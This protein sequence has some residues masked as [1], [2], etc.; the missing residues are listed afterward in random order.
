[1]DYAFSDFSAPEPRSRRRVLRELAGLGA[2]AVALG[3]GTGILPEGTPQAMA[4]D[5]V[6]RRPPV[7]ARRFVSP[8]VEAEIARV[9]AMIGDPELAW[10]FANCYPNTLDTTVEIAMRGGKP[11]TFVITGDIPAMWL[12]DSS[13][14]VW[15]YLH[16]ARDDAALQRLYRGLIARHAQCI[17]IDPYANAF[18]RDPGATRTP[19]WWALSDQTQM[20]P[21]VAERK[22]EVDSLCH[23]VRLAYGYWRATGDSAPFDAQWHQAARLIVF[24]LRTEQRRDG[25]SPYRFQRSTP[26]PTDSLPMG[27]MGSPTRKVGLIHSMFRPSDDACVFPFL[28]PSN[29]FAVQALRWLAEIAATVL[30]DGALAHDAVALA[31]EVAAAVQAWGRI[32]DGANAIWAYEV[33]GFGNTLFMDDANAPSLASLAYLGCVARDDPMFRRTEARCWSTANPYYFER[34]GNSGIGGPHVGMNMIW[35]MSLAVRAQSSD[36]PRIVANCLA[37]LKATHAGTGFMH[38]AFEAGNPAHFT[39]IWFAWANGLFGEMMIDLAARMP[40][41]LGAGR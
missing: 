9:S 31:D 6:S 24:T 1:M 19:L 23:V 14:Q 34:G 11:D 16:L 35:P 2:V 20:R 22:W 17:L 38:E 10:L 21:G 32:G 40:D 25:T 41:L 36:D 30:H 4:A 33:D 18:G 12:R 37:Q 5:F 7:S 27:G 3:E 28:I 39:R 8:A 29:L 15:G 13:A 26:S